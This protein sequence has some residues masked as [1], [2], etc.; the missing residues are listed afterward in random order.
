MNN[1]KFTINI[2]AAPLVIA[3]CAFIAVSLVKSKKG[4]PIIPK[5]EVVISVAVNLA[6]PETV[7]PIIQSFGNTQSYFN[8]SISSQING[9]IIEISP[10]FEVGASVD[11]GQWLAKINRAD[12]EANL[13]SRQAAYA[14]ARTAYAEE[15]TRSLLAEEDWLAA[16]RELSEA[17]DLTLRKPQ[18]EAAKAAVESA[19][20][21][22]AQAE[23]DLERTSIRAPFDAIVNQRSA[24]PG[25]VVSRGADL[26]SLI[27]RDRI[28]VRLPLTPSQ[29]SR[30]TLPSFDS[31]ASN[32]HATLTTPTLPGIEW[33]ALI[34]RVEPLIDPKNQSVYLVGEIK[35]PFE[36]PDAFLPVGA[37]V[38]AAIR[39]NPMEDVFK[40]PE[41]AVVEDAFVWIVSPDNTLAK[42]PIT[43]AFSQDGQIYARILEPLYNLPLKVLSLPLASLK[44]GQKV[45][46]VLPDA[47]S[48]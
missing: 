38:N 2:V 30:L 44:S 41:S 10:A 4:P 15:Q 6:Q 19:Q 46:A 25:N 9:E 12:F 20:A 48:N 31:E 23:L 28:Q 27:A 32:L 34:T 24:S 43:I 40:F 42:Q 21:A 45:I 17:S 33:D 47:T 22:V 29:A 35:N 7:T 3:L 37:F 26:G 39:A 16:G 8:T 36:N 11:K 13:A 18:L 1:F 14:T 5:K